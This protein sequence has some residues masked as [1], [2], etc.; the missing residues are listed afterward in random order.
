MFSIVYFPPLIQLL[1]LYWF[2]PISKIVYPYFI[3][4]AQWEFSI[5]KGM[6]IRFL[7]KAGFKL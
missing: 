5:Q 3:G 4:I 6:K 7:A 2:R 1:I